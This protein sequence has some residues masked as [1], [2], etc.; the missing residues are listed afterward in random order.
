MT[1]LPLNPTFINLLREKGINQAVIID[2]AYDLPWPIERGILTEFWSEIIADDDSRQLL[3]D[4]IKRDPSHLETITEDVVLRLW[5][6]R[7]TLE[8]P[9][10]GLCKNILFATNHEK[11]AQLSI[12]ANH[13]NEAGIQLHP[14]GQDGSIP[15]EVRAP[16]IFI[17]YYMGA[18][19]DPN[20]VARSIAITRSIYEKYGNEHKPL[21]ILI[22]SVPNVHQLQE[23]FR[24]ES[25]LLGGM[26]YFVTKD[27]L[28]N[29]E[30]F[31][32][33]LGA[34]VKNLP[35]GYMI[36]EFID[37]LE[38]SFDSVKSAFLKDIRSLSITDY[39]YIQNLS[40]QRD[41]HPLGEYMRWLYGAHLLNMLFTQEQVVRGTQANMNKFRVESPPLSQSTPSLRLAEIYKSAL[42]EHADPVAGHPG[43]PIANG[44]ESLPPLLHLGDVFLNQAKNR[45]WMVI[46]AECDLAISA[47]G[48]RSI[49]DE[50][51]IFL[52]PGVLQPL[53]ALAT[54]FNSVR[55][56]LFEHE[57][58]KYRIIWNT[59]NVL[60]QPYGNFRDWMKS[61]G[62]ERIARLQ[63][64]YALEVQRAFSSELTRI[65]MPVPPP[66]YRSVKVQFLY[67]GLN[68]QIEQ[69][70]QPMDNLAFLVVM[71][72]RKEN[73]DIHVEKCV[74][75]IE[76]G[77]KLKVEVDRKLESLVA[78]GAVENFKGNA[79]SV[80][81]KASLQYGLLK[82]LREHFDSWFLGLHLVKFPDTRDDGAS[83]IDLRASGG[84]VLLPRDR[85]PIRFRRNFDVQRPPS[86]AGIFLINIIE[87]VEQQA[88]VEV[89]K[90][91]GLDIG[92]LAD[93][94][95]V[96]VPNEVKEAGTNE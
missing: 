88:P 78:M 18:D 14:V 23:S 46:N 89:K 12:F 55:T 1:Q 87:D 47:D 76:L 44:E 36:Q 92:G 73:V 25:H 28:A 65:G 52:I 21:I 59:K 58:Q 61:F 48:R 37:A 80:E 34:W 40:L 32:L 83:P 62:C 3:R 42:F 8:E 41:G 10:K 75:T 26:F 31:F 22:S 39:A 86:T 66:F 24:D 96:A 2:D 4:F 93:S 15:D 69:L 95:G 57:G 16:I 13:L 54:E 64:P 53:S 72:E 79:K 20:A 35:T 63:Q 70:G 6:Y 43:A 27:D 84:E 49:P 51:S 17:D 30:K 45:I 74:F 67:R 9:L 29:P 11:L 71:K 60:A 82:L 94:N 38:S 7:E 56:E 68:N 5:E 19:H 90:N 91:G 85:I 77:F 50:Q 81:A 33:Q